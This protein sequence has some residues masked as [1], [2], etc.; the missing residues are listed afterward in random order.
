MGCQGA[1]W[2]GP[3]SKS[4]WGLP[5]CGGSL[6]NQSQR[7]LEPCG[8]RFVPALRWKVV[9]GPMAVHS[10]CRVRKRGGSSQVCW[11]SASLVLAQHLACLPLPVCTWTRSVWAD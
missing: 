10:A 4:A 1:P 2:D 7:R 5:V 11:T 6:Y 9:R 3:V 8:E